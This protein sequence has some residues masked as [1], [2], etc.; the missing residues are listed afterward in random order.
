MAHGYKLLA[1]PHPPQAADV[2]GS[3]A[4]RPRISRP[5]PKLAGSAGLFAVA[6]LATGCVAGR[7][8]DPRDAARG[9]ADAARRGDADAIYDML[10][11][12]GRRSLSRDEVRRIVKDERGELADEAKALT[13]P[14]AVVKARARV[15]YADGEVATLVLDDE[16]VFR[17]G[18]ADAL[19][20]GARTPEQ[21]L[22]QLRRVLARRSYAGL[23]RVLSPTT[24][25][26]IEN[27]LRSLVTGL[28]H[29]EGL[30]VNVV[31]DSATVEVPGGHQVRLKR[32][33]GTWHVEDFD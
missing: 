15:R 24:R 29:P 12:K 32:E 26:A 31:G 25:S 28:D 13:S 8:P 16:G 22:E 14:S 27:D 23:M 5:S 1:L 2:L 4:V 30:E 33:G 19:P 6:A 7:V 21:A 3:P 9:Y 11:E 17:I 18:A 10:S 20:A